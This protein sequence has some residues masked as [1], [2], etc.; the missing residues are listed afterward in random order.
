[1]EKWEIWCCYCLGNDH[2]KATN[3]ITRLLVATIF[4]RPVIPKNFALLSKVMTSWYFSNGSDSHQVVL[5][6][7]S[8]C[9]ERELLNAKLICLKM[10]SNKKANYVRGQFSITKTDCMWKDWRQWQKTRRFH[11]HILDMGEDDSD[12]W[13]S[14]AGWIEVANT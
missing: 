7:L 10:E 3:I 9:M 2:F 14:I 6:L 11:I 12:T 8:I 4:W 5:M 13:G 1:M